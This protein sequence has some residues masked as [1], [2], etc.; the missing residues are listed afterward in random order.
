[1]HWQE[2]FENT[3]ASVIWSVIFTNMRD[4]EEY[5]KV[6]CTGNISFTLSNSGKI[7]RSHREFGVCWC[8]LQQQSGYLFTRFLP[9]LTLKVRPTLQIC[10]SGL[11]CKRCKASK[12]SLL[13]SLEHP[14]WKLAS[15]R[16]FSHYK[17]VLLWTRPISLNNAFYLNRAYSQ[18]MLNRGK[19]F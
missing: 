14:P 9:Y 4:T 6:I 19:D 17:E 3:T 13:P 11:I 8:R 7:V 2:S 15:E 18:L 10:G 12:C 1:M 16:I 5:T